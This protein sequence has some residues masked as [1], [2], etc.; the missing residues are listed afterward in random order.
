MGAFTLLRVLRGPGRDTGERTPEVGAPQIPRRAAVVFGLLVTLAAPSPA[1]ATARKVAASLDAARAPARE[2]KQTD[3]VP[4]PGGATVYRFQQRV[5]GVTVLGGEAVVNEA[6]SAPPALVA[7]ASKP[8]VDSPPSPRIS[9]AQATGIA[10][11][12]AGVESVRG[13]SSAAL[14]IQPG[15]GGTLVWRVLIPS[16]RPLADFELLVDARS[17]EVLRARNLLRDFRTGRAKLYNPNPVVEHGSFHGLRSDHHDRDTP[18]LT[19]LRRQVSLRDIN[20]GQDC[21]RGRW[22]HAK[23]G[24]HGGHEVCKGSLNWK[25]VTRSRNRF[26]ALMAY[27]Q[28]DRAQRYIQSLGFSDASANGVNDHTQVAIA[29]AFKADNDFYSP[30]DRKIRYGTGGV[31]DAEDADVILHEYGHAMQDS[32]AQ[33][34]FLDSGNFSQPG[35]L[36]EGSA[37]YWAAAM[38]AQS[39]G[40]TNVDDVCIFDWDGSTW[41][42]VVHPFDRHCG[43]R[44]DIPSKLAQ[45]QASCGFEIHCVG[46]VWSSALWNLRTELGTD[47]AGRS[48]IDRDYLAAQFMYHA[49][50]G[51]DDAAQALLDADADLYGGAH[52]D[53]ICAEMETN[54]GIDVAGCP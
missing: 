40:T 30:F 45:K 52:H 2:L 23:L 32:S 50:E 26:E 3:A 36:A 18:L 33:P 7:D 21:L 8:S 31:D 22:V 24:R 10:T 54:R 39:P 25:R 38:S 16:A 1:S 27:F 12:T 4:L 49:G 13:R 5:S 19:A 20:S 46:E 41:G 28:I 43:R 11:R 9:K 35:A 17:G 14:A 53:A 51:F 34:G 48:I 37:D 44:A 29:D 6:P 15:D 47:L 42:P